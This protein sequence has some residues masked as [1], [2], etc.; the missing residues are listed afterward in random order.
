MANPQK[1]HGYTA[2]ANELLDWIARAPL[3]GSQFRLLMTVVRKT[4]GFNRKEDRISAT[5]FHEATGLHKQVVARELRDLAKRGYLVSIGDI[6]HAKSYQIQKNYQLWD[7]GQVYTDWL[8]DQA[9]QVYTDPPTEPA[10]VYTDLLT[11]VYTDPLTTKD[12]KTKRTESHDSGASPP[13]FS[14]GTIRERFE[15]EYKAAT[16]QRERVAVV[17]RYFEQ[18]LGPPDFPRLARLLKDAG[19]GG[20]LFGFMAEAAKFTITD[21]PHSYVAKIMQRAKSG[22]GGFKTS[23]DHNSAKW[24]AAT[25]R[26]V[27]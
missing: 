4:Y 6:H 14:V 5:Q 23:A 3:N 2:L 20:A 19:S 1:E 16:G 12:R 18:M 22:G 10:Q 25:G 7:G 8:T 26:A 9:E 11:E 13:P 21:D 24:A 15:A 17:G 27:Q